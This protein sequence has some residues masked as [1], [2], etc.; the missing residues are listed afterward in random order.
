MVTVA[1]FNKRTIFVSVTRIEK[2][3]RQYGIVLQPKDYSC[4][5][6]KLKGLNLQKARQCEWLAAVS[7]Q[8]I[9]GVW[10]IDPNFGWRTM[11]RAMNPKVQQA[12]D[13]DRKYCA[14]KNL[15]KELERKLLN[16]LVSVRLYSPFNFNF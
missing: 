15:S 1:G 11:R 16:P 13:P 14:L 3:L 10:A 12:I 8:R 7:G 2:E 4:G 6:W 9:V 5:N